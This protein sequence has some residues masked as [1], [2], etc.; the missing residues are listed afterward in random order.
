M[1][2]T[3]HRVPAE[4][5]APLCA[6]ASEVCWTVWAVSS[7]LRLVL[8]PVLEPHVSAWVGSEVSALF[9]ERMGVL[10]ALAVFGLFGSFG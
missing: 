1:K 10:A 9:W 6:D 5:D 4:A 3:I 2:K 7:P 8:V